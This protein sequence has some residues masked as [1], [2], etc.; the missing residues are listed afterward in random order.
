MFY[1]LFFVVKTLLFQILSDFVGFVKGRV[2]QCD[3]PLIAL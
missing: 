1:D 3:T 2:L